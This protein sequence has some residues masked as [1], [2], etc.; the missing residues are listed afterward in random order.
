MPF[1]CPAGQLLMYIKATNL[2]LLVVLLATKGREPA[3]R[4]PSLCWGHFLNIPSK[5]D[6][7]KKRSACFVTHY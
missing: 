3:K 2:F 7:R 1:I 6:D 4:G 5:A